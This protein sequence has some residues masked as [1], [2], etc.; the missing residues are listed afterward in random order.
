MV[1][2]KGR[3][4]LTLR[5]S[6]HEYV[7]ST[8]QES[9]RSQMLLSLSSDYYLD[10]LL[11]PSLEG[12]RGHKAALWFL[13]KIPPQR[14]H[15]N[16]SSN[17]C[18]WRWKWADLGCIWWRRIKP[19]RHGIWQ[20]ARVTKGYQ[21]ENRP[22]APSRRP[23]YT[24]IRKTS[25]SAAETWR[26]YSP[27]FYAWGFLSWPLPLSAGLLCRNQRGVDIQCVISKNMGD[28][29]FPSLRG[30]CCKEGEVFLSHYH[31]FRGVVHVS[32]RLS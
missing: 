6:Q 21:T 24:K 11:L 18:E 12:V 25:G 4:S 22:G 27:L 9:W 14:K 30:L 29:L 15:K 3:C 7:Q 16:D 10:M 23:S 17:C 8:L 19:T 26:R 28:M 1:V 13:Q 32:Q 31:R 20:C 5:C 2:S